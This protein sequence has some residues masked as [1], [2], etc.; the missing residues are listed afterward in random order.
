MHAN[1]PIHPNREQLAA[2]GLGKLDDAET[3][4]V[5]EH[6]ETCEA[7]QKTVGDT[8]SDTF[9][10][11]LHAARPAPELALLPELA[12]H[13][14]FR[15]VREL[16]RGGMGV[17]YLAEH[18]L[19]ERQVAIKVISR[20][21]VENR[22][23]LERFHRE[24]R[25]AAKLDHENIVGAYDAEQAGDS[26]ILV[27][28]YVE[29]LNLAQALEH[30]G[31]LPVAESCH[32]IRQAALALQHAFEQ[33]MVH[34]DLK[35]Q[36]LML[37]PDKGVI[38]ILDFGLARLASER[39]RGKGLTAEKTIMGTPEYIAPEQALDAAQADIRA[40]I[41]SLGCTL[42]CLLSGRPPFLEQTGMQTILAHLHKEAAPLHG[43]NSDVPAELSAVVAQMLRKDPGQRYQTP[44]AVADALAPFCK[45]SVAVA[46]STGKEL[47]VSGTTSAEV[48]GDQPQELSHRRSRWAVILIIFAA[49]FSLGLVMSIMHLGQS[50]RNLSDMEELDAQVAEGPPGVPRFAKKGALGFG[51]PDLQLGQNQR[52]LSDMEELDV[53]VAEGPPGVP[54]FAKKGALGF[55]QPDL[56]YS[57]GRITVNGK[58]SPHGLSMNPIAEGCATVKYR[59]S[60]KAHKSLASVALDDS[61]G[62]SGLPP[63]VGAIPTPLTFQVFGDGRL[64]WQSQ[65]VAAARIV[66]ECKVD[67][68]GVDVLE[69][70]VLCPGTGDN[71]YAVWLEPRV[72]LN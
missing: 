45:P 6:L 11:A 55:G 49:L 19:M 43:V 64:L 4:M 63:G 7:C 16:G 36:N 13:P 38:K 44:R 18:R 34:R 40:D 39:Q 8:P 25:A 57:Y 26:P 60:K 58:G 32:Y 21:L 50:R 24:V 41:Y 14:R 68:S 37:Q 48:T 9:V 5:V 20:A 46:V 42:Y 51:Q 30:R 3:A 72:L 52:Y 69:L 23:A 17:V 2:Y 54:R 53:Q 62:G 66:Q 70:R 22:E 1:A 35:P 67:V 59:L 29:G 28:E 71:A 27:M 15:I 56:R 31:A 33:G 12:N 10:H 65:P 47:V 61:A